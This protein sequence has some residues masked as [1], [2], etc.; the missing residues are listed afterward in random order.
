MYGQDER[1]LIKPTKALLESTTFHKNLREERYEVDRFQADTAI[2]S[3]S[4]FSTI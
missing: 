2:I 3:D 1:R 4:R